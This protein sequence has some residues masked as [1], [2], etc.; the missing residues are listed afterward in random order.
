MYRG[1]LKKNND[2]E[3]ITNI[4]PLYISLK[5]I[6]NQVLYYICSTRYLFFLSTNYLFDKIKAMYLSTSYQFYFLFFLNKL[7][8]LFFIFFK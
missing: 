6:N 8:I 2:G 5:K 7:P 3:W 4:Y 1:T